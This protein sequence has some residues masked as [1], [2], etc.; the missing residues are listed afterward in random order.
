MPSWGGI[1]KP[2]P[3]QRGKQQTKPLALVLL[4]S[5]SSVPCVPSPE[6]PGA[7]HGYAAGQNP[8]SEA[9]GTMPLN[10][11]SWMSRSNSLSEITPLAPSW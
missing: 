3:T 4:P 7:G 11:D 10:V 1:P 9:Q 5:V 6:L 2:H 8:S